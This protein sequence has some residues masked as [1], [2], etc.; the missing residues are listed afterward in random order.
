MFD[1]FRNWRPVRVIAASFQTMIALFLFGCVCVSYL[2][3]PL[4]MFA[5]N[6]PQFSVGTFSTSSLV[7]AFTVTG[8]LIIAFGW[9][10]WLSSISIAS[11]LAILLVTFGLASYAIPDIAMHILQFLLTGD[12]SQLERFFG[13]TQS[14][15]ATVVGILEQ[16]LF[17]AIVLPTGVALAAAVQR[18]LVASRFEELAIRRLRLRRGGVWIALIA[19]FI[20]VFNHVAHV[21]VPTTSQVLREEAFSVKLRQGIIPGMRG[22]LF[23]EEGVVTA[24]KVFRRLWRIACGVI[25]LSIEFVPLWASDLV[26]L[27]ME[28]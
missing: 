12:W 4:S 16:P 13:A 18:L 9:H 15:S 1:G 7:L 21:V 14:A 22:F 5:N 23:G 26:D 24:N 8:I 2:P 25:L 17:V 11:Q 27:V 28:G 19:F 3:P 6:L 10:S 20:R